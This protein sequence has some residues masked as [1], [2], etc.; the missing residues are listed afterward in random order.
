MEWGIDVLSSVGTF[1]KSS[2]SL[3]QPWRNK[4]VGGGEVTRQFLLLLTQLVL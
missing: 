1:G 3:C 4:I 2:P